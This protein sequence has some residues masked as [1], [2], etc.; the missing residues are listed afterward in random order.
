MSPDVRTPL[1]SVDQTARK[2]RENPIVLAGLRQRQRAAFAACRGRYTPATPSG[3]PLLGQAVRPVAYRPSLPTSVRLLQSCVLPEVVEV[4]LRRDDV[5]LELMRDSMAN[6][7]AATRDGSENG[8]DSGNSLHSRLPTDFDVHGYVKNNPKLRALSPAALPGHYLEVGQAQGLGYRRSLDHSFYKLLYFPGTSVSHSFL[9]Q[10]LLKANRNGYANLT[11]MLTDNGFDQSEWVNAF[12][13]KAYIAANTLGFSIQ[14]E[15]Q[16]LKHLVERGARDLL[17]LSRTLHFDPVFY[18]AFAGIEGDEPQHLYRH[19]LQTGLTAGTPPNESA[20]LRRENIQLDEIPSSFDEMVYLEHDP[21]LA[22][23]SPRRWQS[24]H[25]FVTQGILSGG[26]LPFS[27]GPIVGVLVAAGTCHALQGRDT[28]A[29]AIYERALLED[30][31]NGELLQ[32]LGDIAFRDQKFTRAR[33]FYQRARASGA[34]G[35]WNWLNA[36]AAATSTADHEEAISLLVRGLERFPRDH[37]MTSKLTDVLTQFG[38]RAGSAFRVRLARPGPQGLVNEGIARD[39]GVVVKALG[40]VRVNGE[41]RCLEI[42]AGEPLQVVLLANRDLPQCTFYRVSQK[43]EQILGQAVHLTILDQAQ[44]GEFKDAIATADLAIFYRTIASAPIIACIIAC[45]SAGVPTVYE[46]DDL[47]FDPAY[48]PEPI[49]S[50]SG[51]INATEHLWLRYGV[52]MFRHALALCDYAIASTDHLADMMAHVIGRDRVIV[53]RNGLSRQLEILAQH[54]GFERPVSD[55]INVFYGSGTKAHTS[56]FIELVEPALIAVMDGNPTVH[57]TLCGHVEAPSLK[58]RFPLRVEHIDF[59]PDRDAYLALLRRAHI[60]LAVLSESLFNDCKSEIKWLEAAALSIPTLA[61]RVGGL[62]ETTTAGVDVMLAS[63]PQ[64]WENEIHRLCNDAGLRSRV[65]SAAR[66]KALDLYRPA[67]LGQRLTSAL[68]KLHDGAI[69]GRPARQRPRIL[70]VNV[71]FTP[72][73][74]GGATR[75]VRD[76]IDGLLDSHGQSF[77]IGVACGNADPGTDYALNRYFYRS[78]PVFQIDT[79]LR[80]FMDW[81]SDDDGVSAPF[82][83]ILDYFRPDLVHFHC[84]QRL[85]AGIVD[86]TIA[87]DI[88]FVVTVHDAWWVSDHQFLHDGLHRLRYPW[89][90]EEFDSDANPHNRSESGRRKMRLFTALSQASQVLGVSRYF[91][92]LYRQCGVNNAIAVPNG[93]SALKGVEKRAAHKGRIR[94]GHVGGGS[95]HKGYDLLRSTITA[96]GY[97]DFEVIA[98]DHEMSMGQER[99]EIWGSTS[100]TISGPVAQE[101]VAGLYARMDVLVAP[102]LWPESFGLVTRE[103]LTCGAWVIASSLGALG[104]DIEEGI[105]GFLVDVQKPNALA[106]ILD[107]IYANPDRFRKPPKIRKRL[108]MVEDQ[109]D[110]VAKLYHVIIDKKRSSRKVSHVSWVDQTIMGR[111]QSLHCV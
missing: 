40:A 60:N 43:A 49:E 21:W 68:L 38:D 83:R 3:L 106:S 53:H 85:G 86:L 58:T 102:S 48:Y 77:E 65:A 31:T 54:A 55:Q 52:P 12:R 80:E 2:M 36:A 101:Q 1:P 16:A 79:P 70:I 56:D 27:G 57:I 25:H 73:T 6:A 93:V 61:S 41:P 110:D 67:D 95:A 13:F 74:I 20:Y 63:S 82:A 111:P 81:R 71:F 4:D 98:I 51:L 45:R 108:R 30:D 15:M 84:I 39:I 8:L 35:Y 24:F 19:W 14:N 100:V 89:D 26:P 9:E 69:V 92:E 44:V 37:R 76:Q 33:Y 66:K 97:R 28:Q 29:A 50:F 59:I 42:A 32:A 94:L 62:T 46:I 99:K 18:A 5:R 7:G 11:E 104:E 103:A 22:E 105:N 91:T 78:V 88:P 17:P 96:G 10:H 90:A 107:N 109:V 64:E 47:V 87:R 34:G 23:R 75:V 72:Q